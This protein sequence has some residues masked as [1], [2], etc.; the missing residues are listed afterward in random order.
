MATFPDESDSRAR[1][2]FLPNE[3]APVALSSP[4]S[5]LPLAGGIL[6]AVGA[7]A[8]LVLALAFFGSGHLLLVKLGVPI[9]S[10]LFALGSCLLVS[11]A[12]QGRERSAWVLMGLACL[13]ALLAQGARMVPLFTGKGLAEDAGAGY[14]SLAS[15]ALIAQSLG[16]FLAFLL[17]PPPTQGASLAAR[18]EQFFDGVLAVGAALLAVIYFVL[19]P[20]AQNTNGTLTAA[21]LTTLTICVSD[22]LL[23]GGLTF[24]LRSVDLRHSPLY[25]ALSILGL[26]MLLLVSA[27]FI[28]MVQTPNQLA[29][30]DSPLQAIWN[31]GYLMVGLG[32][33]RRLRGGNHE[34]SPQEGA[35]TPEKSQ[36]IWRVLPFAL[37]VVVAGSIVVHAVTRA[38]TSTERLVALVCASL[39]VAL[40]GL[41]H[42]VG[43][44]EAR[45]QNEQRRA[46]ERQVA[47]AEEQ[48]EQ[49][50]SSQIAQARARQESLE[51]V[52]D[53]LMRFG[54]GDFQ[55]RVGTLE[56]DLAPLADQLNTL[57]DGIDRQL[58]DRDRGREMRLIHVLTDALGRL[59]L[60]ELHDLPELPS[61][62]GSP[63]DGLIMSVVQVRTRL[64]SLQG[65]IQQ[66]EQ[67]H[68]A[69]QQELERARQELEQERLAQH[70]ATLEMNQTL[71][72]QL[73]SER[74]VALA[75]EEQ[76]QRERQRLQAQVQAAEARVAEVEAMLHAAE[77]RLVNER[78]EAEQR[79]Q[80]ERQALEARQQ[81]AARSGPLQLD[82]ARVRG[83]QLVRQFTIQAERLHTAA[84]TLQTAAEVTQRLASMIR[85]TAALPEM[86][87]KNQPAAAAQAPAAG[88]VVEAAAPA[89]A[90]SALQMLERLA[91]GRGLDTTPK[92]PAVAPASA[93]AGESAA[94]ASTGP[95]NESANERVARRLGAAA[96]RAEEIAGGLLELAMR[97]I[98]AGDDSARAAEEASKLTAELEPPKVPGSI[99]RTALP[100][101]A[102]KARR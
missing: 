1:H 94:R 73:Y 20:F 37:A 78:L 33:L 96:S 18:L 87:D 16:F 7:E 66:Y 61:P 27:D 45:R 80:A 70:Q 68:Y 72:G 21:Q 95:L 41:R 57:L 46:L 89:K 92:M 53:T 88:Q 25:G 44:F 67:E 22:L 71:E 90:L 98:Q 60:G 97:C 36:N 14:P 15:A 93:P 10:A 83:E 82:D 48:V 101:R 81:E 30:A 62:A 26:A 8:L 99:Q 85:E 39:L 13:G 6:L 28:S 100:L 31:A 51:Y 69:A 23:L 9:I 75:T 38:T 35:A 11:M 77:Q 49:L 52:L 55:A 40:M 86:R 59:A 17:F 47:L 64:M 84:A 63:L 2:G 19:V 12:F 65:M 50:R 91:E 102:P 74:Q 5:R 34:T 76:W 3:A 43:L 54:Y 79:L 58:N 4:A 56:R 32:A 29:P 24:A 42:L